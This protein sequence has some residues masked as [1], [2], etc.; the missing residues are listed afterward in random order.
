VAL[1]GRSPNVSFCGG[2]SSIPGQAL[3]DVEVPADLPVLAVAHDV[4]ARL[5]LAAHHVAYRSLEQVLLFAGVHLLAAR[6][7][8]HDRDHVIGPDQTPDVSR[9]DRVRVAGHR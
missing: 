9:L 4:D 5:L 1:I 2:R 6:D 7:A 3:V 8:A